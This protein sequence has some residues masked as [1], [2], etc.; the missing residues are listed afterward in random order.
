MIDDQ[1]RVITLMTA[2]VGMKVLD[3]DCYTWWFGFGNR[4][5]IIEIVLT[6]QDHCIVGIYLWCKN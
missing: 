5:A 2:V 3:I 6:M 4:R 1:Q